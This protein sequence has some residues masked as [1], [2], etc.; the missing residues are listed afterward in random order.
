VA[1]SCVHDNNQ[2]A[3]AAADARCA[4][5]GSHGRTH[6]VRRTIDAGI[7]RRR[8]MSTL[9]IADDHAVI[10]EAL[11]SLLTA[12]G[13]R[14]VGHAGDIVRADAGIAASDPQVILLDLALSGESGFDLLLRLRERGLEAR[15]IVLTLSDRGD[16]VR[17]ALELGA[18][19]YVL[20]ASP[21]AELLQAVQAV[22]SGSQHVPD[23]LRQRAARANGRT[24]QAADSA[25]AL[26]SARERQILVMVARGAS[27]SAIGVR[28]SL[29]PKTVDTYRSR[30]MRKL[31]LANVPD[32]VRWTVRAGWIGLED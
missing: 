4:R 2:N 10:R 20:K 13:H 9:Y 3:G 29:S 18:G 5:S 30:L 22:A 19:G 24:A 7:A 21:A 1:L 8:S 28:L 27:S 31:S 23:A 26:L 25:A 32:L 17:R 11:E 16:D 12:A 15:V 14:V 6:R